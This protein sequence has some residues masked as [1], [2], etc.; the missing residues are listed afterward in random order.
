MNTPTNSTHRSTAR[1]ATTCAL[2]AAAWVAL[3]SPVLRAESEKGSEGK[4][5]SS[6]PVKL[7]LIGL[8][9]KTGSDAAAKEFNS[10]VLPSINKLINV[11]L[12]EKTPVNDATM[13]LD[14]TKLTLQT[15]SD[16]RVYFV[17][18]GASYHNVLGLTQGGG[19]L[20]SKNSALIFP[21][22]SSSV[23]SYDPRATGRTEKEP[24]LPGDFVNVGKFDK[25]TKLDFFIISAGAAI[26]KTLGLKDAITVSQSANIFSTDRSVN[27]D[28]INHVVAFASAGSP[29]LV[30]AFEDMF[31]GGDR[32]F[33]D[34]IIAVDIGAKNVAALTATPEPPLLVTL[35]SCLLVGIWG[36]R[37]ADRNARA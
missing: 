13:L 19:V 22:A 20:S 25:G 1:F 14:P 11:K 16:V 27:K 18:E 7:S 28:G 15:A 33:N 30:L 6:Q 3:G 9:E 26:G 10:T 8:T 31:K 36:K 32:D 2:A 29:Y 35:G 4:E 24:L 34:V 12:S 17:G 5:G 23:S 21:D 37:R